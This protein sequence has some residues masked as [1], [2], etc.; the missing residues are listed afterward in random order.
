MALPTATHYLANVD[1]DA[2]FATSFNNAA[3]TALTE[4]E[5]TLALGEATRWLEQLCWKGTKCSDTQPLQWPRKADKTSCCA[6]VVC[7]A[8]PTQLVA[9]TA[10]LALA[11]HQN[12]TAIIG[13]SSSSGAIRRAQLGGLS[14]EYFEGGAGSASKYGANA[15][16]LLQRF[17]WLGDLLGE[18]YM[19]GSFGRSRIIARVRS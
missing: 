7:T 10:E 9:A 3:W 14:V 8:L 16:L 5:K 4:P 11:L 2:H 19:D 12:K 6:A 17:P 15:P 13:G 1:A 18:C